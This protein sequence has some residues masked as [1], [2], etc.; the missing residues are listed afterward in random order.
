MIEK[1][2]KGLKRLKLNHQRKRI[3]EGQQ[4][5]WKV[6]WGY[7][8]KLCRNNSCLKKFCICLEEREDEWYIKKK[9]IRNNELP[10]GQ[11]V[12]T[13][14]RKGKTRKM[15]KRIRIIEQELQEERKSLYPHKEE[16]ECNMELYRNESNRELW[17][18]R[19]NLAREYIAIERILEQRLWEPRKGRLYK[20]LQ[21][22]SIITH[23]FKP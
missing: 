18:N 11:R 15:E 17:C 13:L 1:Y 8:N 4:H 10:W 3:M 5:Q 23:G 20:K 19:I 16:C 12:R 14:Q 6:T 2:I 21:K 22:D 9:F 7:L